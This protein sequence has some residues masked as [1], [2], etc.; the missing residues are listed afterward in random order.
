MEF[1]NEEIINIVAQMRNAPDH[2]SN[3]KKTSNMLYKCILCKCYLSSN[4]W[5]P[6]LEKTLI[7]N[8]NMVKTKLKTSGDCI[9]TNGKKIEIK[10]SLGDK[11]GGINIVQIRPDHDIDFYLIMVYNIFSG[12]IGEIYYILIDSKSLYNLIP[13]YGGYAHG[14]VEKLGKITAENINNRN[15]E[16]ALRPNIKIQKPLKCALLWKHILL[17][18]KNFTEIQSVLSSPSL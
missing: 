7:E 1:K 2:I 18:Q 9:S 4:I 16:Y 13:M 15:C 11:N 14:T 8:F 12:D 6:L 17:F 10:I 3:I 5:G